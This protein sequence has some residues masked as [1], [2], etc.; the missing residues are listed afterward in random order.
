MGRS[1]RSCPAGDHLADSPAARFPARPPGHHREPVGAH[2]AL[3]VQDQPFDGALYHGDGL[4]PGTQG[5][6]L[7]PE[8]ELV[9][10]CAPS[11]PRAIT[12]RGAEALA[13]LTHLH[14]SSRPDAWRQ[15]Y[16]A[17][18]YLYGPQAAGRARS[19]W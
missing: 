7:F 6:L 9:P 10:V 14:L 4:W 2:A 11:W 12:G 15:W 18:Q 19:R 8:R 17:N 3:P 1:I 5:A 16:A 13:G